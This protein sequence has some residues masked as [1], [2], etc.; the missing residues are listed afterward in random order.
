VF[1]GTNVTIDTTHPDLITIGADVTISTGTT[2]VAHSNPPASIRERF[3]PKTEDEIVIGDNVYVGAGATLLQGV[4]LEDWTI[5]SAG[6][7]V[8]DNVPSYKIVAG[9]PAEVIGDL[10]ER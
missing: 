10:R 8:T 3:M 4:T 5:V 2:I 6:A 7:V 9:N 1:I